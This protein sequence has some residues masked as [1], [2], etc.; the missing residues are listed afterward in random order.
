MP[1]TSQASWLKALFIPSVLLNPPVTI[2]GPLKTD[3]MSFA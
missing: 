2:K 3:L 1:I